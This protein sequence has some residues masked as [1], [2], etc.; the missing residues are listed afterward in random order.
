MA[1]L[2][3]LPCCFPYDIIKD[4]SGDGEHSRMHCLQNKL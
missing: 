2:V 1:T 3:V 4:P